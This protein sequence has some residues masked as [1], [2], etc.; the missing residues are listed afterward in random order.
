MSRHFRISVVLLTLWL[1]LPALSWCQA[2]PSQN[3]P[4]PPPG[5]PMPMPS[6]MQMTNIPYFTLRDGMNSTLTLNNTALEQ[7]PNVTV[8]IYNSE[9]RSQ[10]LPAI[11][12]EGHSFKQIELRDVVASDLFDSGSLEVSY[13]GTP[14]LVTC[15]LSVSS[16]DKRVSFE[17]REQSMMDFESSNLNGILSVPDKA[18]GFLAMTNVAANPVKVTLSIGSKTKVFALQ[19]HETQVAKLNEELQGRSVSLVALQHDGKPGSIVTTGFVLDLKNGYSATFMMHDPKLMRSSLL[20]GAHVRFGQPDAAEGFPDGTLFRAPLL[21][22]N[23]SD[24][25]VNAHVS[26]DYTS[27]EKLKMS[28]IANKQDTQDTLSTAAIRDVNIAPGD[29]QTIELAQ[30]MARFDIDGPVLEAGVEIAYDAAPG[31]LIALLTSVDQS[32]DY[33]FEVPIK[34]P[35]AIGEMPQ[36]VYPW[37]LENGVVSTLHLKNYTDKKQLARLEVR[38]AGGTY[39]PK[40]LVL[41]PHQ[42]MAIDIRKLRDSQ[43]PDEHGQ[44]IPASVTHGQLWW[45]PRANKTI[46]GRNEEVNITHGIARSFSC[47]NM[48]C[49]THFANFQLV[50]SGG[51]SAPLV[52]LEQDWTCN[53]P[54]N[55]YWTSWYDTYGSWSS[56]DNTV[57]WIDPNYWGDSAPITPGSNGGNATITASIAWD[58]FVPMGDGGQMYCDDNSMLS[59]T[60]LG[61][62]YRL[63]AY[64]LSYQTMSVCYWSP[65]CNGTCSQ[66]HTTNTNSSGGCYITGPYK[67]CLDIIINGSCVDY[68]TVCAGRVLPGLCT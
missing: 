55:Y 35:S 66:A 32:G 11:T 15:Q 16:T 21:L 68:R 2:P 44:V 18:E 3:P 33:A 24:Q 41:A 6:G 37:T 27:R 54:T 39:S 34:D 47:G 40:M 65:T 17:S 59:N 50:S 22:A 30:E 31:A 23:V 43:T 14:M 60:S 28:P 42:T 45:G 57:A 1:T 53:S 56:S 12:L 25:P 67:Q 4:A 36:G 5:A 19:P 62:G 64:G 20:A 8:T 38:F 29:V 26:A 51:G 46:I 7:V 52:S 63:S 61:V 48:C 9:G 10:V 58:Q 13:M 49:G